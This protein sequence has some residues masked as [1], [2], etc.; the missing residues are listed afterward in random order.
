MQNVI[1]T[2]VAAEE[3]AERKVREA[4]DKAAALLNKAEAETAETLRVLRQTERDASAALLEEAEAEAARL[5]REAQEEGL[6]D[7]RRE[8]SH[9]SPGIPELAEKVVARILRT[10]FDGGTR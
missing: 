1:K 8:S 9:P 6:E 3:D 5:L 10:V 7:F 2:I 4:R